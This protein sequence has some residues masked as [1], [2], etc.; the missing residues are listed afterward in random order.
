MV[1]IETCLQELT[2]SESESNWRQIWV[3]MNMKS[4]ILGIKQT[5]LAWILQCFHNS[6]WVVYFEMQTSA[7][8][9]FQFC[10]AMASWQFCERG[11]NG[12]GDATLGE[13][14]SFGHFSEKDISNILIGSFNCEILKRERAEIFLLDFLIASL[15]LSC[16]VYFSVLR[17]DWNL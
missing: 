2:K 12:R 4:V 13:K 16:E 11:C 15:R 9:V 1:D 17:F 8:I 6:V 7:N 3:K 10:W 5:N 14:I